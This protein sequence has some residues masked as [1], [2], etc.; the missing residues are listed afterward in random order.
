MKPLA[1][2][3]FGAPAKQRRFRPPYASLTVAASAPS[4]FP[5][6][7]ALSAPHVFAGDFLLSGV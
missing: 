7:E 6:V 2:L 3:H 1:A 4:V 5:A